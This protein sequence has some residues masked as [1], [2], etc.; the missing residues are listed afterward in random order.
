MSKKAPAPQAAVPA[1]P[2]MTVTPN[3]PYPRLPWEQSPVATDS[4]PE[5]PET[6]EEPEAVEETA[7]APA[8]TTA[9]AESAESPDPV[10]GQP[11]ETTDDEAEGDRL[12]QADYTRKTQELASE[13]KAWEAARAKEEIE[14]KNLRQQHGQYLQALEA[15]LRENLPKEL[16]A[17]EWD[18]EFEADP[19]AAQ[20]KWAKFQTQ[21]EEHQ[22]VWAQRQAFETEQSAEHQRRITEIRAEESRLLFQKVPD[23][24]K[25]EAQ[26]AVV[27]YLIADGYT[28]DQIEAAL[29]HRPFLHAYK[30][31]L[32]DELQA[33]TKTV[34][35]KAT[36][37]LKPGAK[38]NVSAGSDLEKKVEAARRK[39]AATGSINDNADYLMLKQQL[40]KAS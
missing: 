21:R 36:P 8:A 2:R 5:Q 1:K 3:D 34:K 19:V 13:R 22:R 15:A 40:A 18:A 17:A 27:K 6:A 14:I 7:P 35:A 33:K 12:R 30:A 23:L 16:S 24:A 28:N 31:H 25:P 20:R 9:E 26:Q 11:E 32:W 38:S 4:A 29:D 37:V 10:E 39:A